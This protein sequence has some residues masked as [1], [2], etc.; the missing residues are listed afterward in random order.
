LPA[1]VR[2]EIENCRYHARASDDDD[3]IGEAIAQSA[4]AP[5]VY[6]HSS[7]EN[8][9]GVSLSRVLLPL[10]MR[11]CGNARTIQGKM[12][13]RC[14]RAATL[15]LFLDFS[16]ALRLFPLHPAQL[17][18]RDFRFT[19]QTAVKAFCNPVKDVPREKIDFAAGRALCHVLKRIHAPPA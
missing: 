18:T 12:R 13:E 17:S 14:D 9:S 1:A 7:S 8:P 2:L 5:S 19:T 10:S 4:E 11:K 6:L 3:A 16:L 15:F